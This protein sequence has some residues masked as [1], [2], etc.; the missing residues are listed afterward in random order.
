MGAEAS[1]PQH[2]EPHCTTLDD[3]SPRWTTLGQEKRGS[4]V[5]A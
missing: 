3:A 5:P 4:L 2:T 1:G